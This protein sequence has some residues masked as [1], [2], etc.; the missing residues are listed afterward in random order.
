MPV[1]HQDKRMLVERNLLGWKLAVDTKA[2]AEAY[3]RL[4]LDC[5]CTYCQN[6]S[7]AVVALPEQLL[8]LLHDLGVDP[9][10]PANTSD[11]GRQPND[12]HLYDAFYHVV[13]TIRDDRAVMRNQFGRVQLAP[14]V[15]LLLN[16]DVSLVPPDFPTPVF[17]VEAS[18]LLPWLLAQPPEPN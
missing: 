11:Y 16:N 5:T 2:T 8:G 3:Q 1:M 7:K 15:D 12:L 4:T 13:G 17:Q 6:F 10:K 9:A 18:F 14:Q